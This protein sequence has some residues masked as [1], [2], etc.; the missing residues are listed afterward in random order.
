MKALRMYAQYLDKKLG[1]KLAKEI[2]K[3]NSYLAISNRGS[4]RSVEIYQNLEDIEE[5]RSNRCEFS[6]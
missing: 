3:N 6:K 1:N 2:T 4:D 5:D